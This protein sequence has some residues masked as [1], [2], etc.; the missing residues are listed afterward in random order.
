M[1]G[2]VAVTV[3]FSEEE[4]YRMTWGTRG[5]NLFKRPGFLMQDSQHLD[6]CRARWV[7]PELA[8]SLAPSDYGLVVVDFV[9]KRILSFQNFTSVDSVHLIHT[10]ID[11]ELLDEMS[12][13]ATNGFIKQVVTWKREEEGKN[14]T[15]LLVP[16]SEYGDVPAAAVVRAQ[17]FFDADFDQNRHSD[18]E[19]FDGAVIPHELILSTPFSVLA[20]TTFPQTM[21]WKM[22]RKAVVDE[23]GFKL[24]Q[25]EEKAWDEW[26]KDMAEAA[27]D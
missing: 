15:R 16:L 22:V 10:R 14:N 24:T 8:G 20:D 21:D 4:Q 12:Q 9:T 23:M 3:R 13:L 7:D 25:E 2:A 18:G 17:A 5:I 6:A 27:K 26:I 11:K 1:G 19:S